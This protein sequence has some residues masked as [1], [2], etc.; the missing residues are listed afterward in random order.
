LAFFVFFC[1]IFYVAIY[2]NKIW[3]SCG[4]FSLCL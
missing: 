3:Y 1:T 4:N 2:T